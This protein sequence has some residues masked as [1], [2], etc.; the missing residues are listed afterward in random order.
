MKITIQERTLAIEA[1][2]GFLSSNVE[3]ILRALYQQDA[4]NRSYTVIDAAPVDEPD[5]KLSTLSL[6]AAAV[7]SEAQGS[8]AWREATDDDVLDYVLAHGG[9]VEYDFEETAEV[10]ESLTEHGLDETVRRGMRSGYLRGIHASGLTP[11]K[12][13]GDLAQTSV[14]TQ[15][16]QVQVIGLLDWSLDW[17]RKTVDATTTDDAEFESSL[18]STKSWTAT[19]NYMF[20]DADPSQQAQILNVITTQGSPTY[21]WN[22]FPTVATGRVAFQGPAII[23][24]IKISSGAG[25]VCATAVSLKGAGPLLVLA[26][27]AP[28]ANPATVTGQSAQV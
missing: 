27:T 7:T 4:E 15:S 8:F 1:P 26:Q 3:Q 6:C 5:A 21:V 11:Q 14:V 17:K 13:L 16:G 19:A 23:D 2:D 9:V 28:V 25:K 24:G 10:L 12:P 20:I 22:F 18:G